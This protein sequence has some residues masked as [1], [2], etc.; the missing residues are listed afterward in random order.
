MTAVVGPAAGLV[1]AS[2]A[3]PAPAA[4][5]GPGARP[6]GAESHSE[7]APDHR[8]GV[9]AAA[10]E[11]VAA[12][13]DREVGP[14]GRARVRWA[15][16]GAGL[17]PPSI[18]HCYRDG[19]PDDRALLRAVVRMLSTRLVSRGFSLS[20]PTDVGPLVARV[21]RGAVLKVAPTWATVGSRAEL[22]RWAD[23]A[24]PRERVRR[25]EVSLAQLVRPEPAAEDV[26]Q[27]AA[28]RR[29]QPVWPPP[30]SNGDGSRLRGGRRASVLSSGGLTP[31]TGC[32]RG[33]RGVRC[34]RVRNGQVRCWECGVVSP[35]PERV[36]GPRVPWCECRELWCLHPVE[37]VVGL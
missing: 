2:S 25:R 30:V 16:V 18:R 31:P 14:A 27:V 15:A 7:P 8:L 26:A 12:A 1:V 29:E 20:D 3:E 19:D 21:P 6:R 22:A 35:V 10:A 4:T 5:G 13:L 36:V 34:V 32:L 24:A 11:R 23:R 33:A 17:M 9:E 37:R 28:I